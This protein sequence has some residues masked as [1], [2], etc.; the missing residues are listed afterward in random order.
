M[1]LQSCPS[2]LACLKPAGISDGLANPRYKRI[3]ISHNYIPTAMD[4]NLL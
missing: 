1:G 3:S 4:S 2:A